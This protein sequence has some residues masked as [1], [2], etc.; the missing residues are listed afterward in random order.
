MT[1]FVGTE[2]D[3]DNIS[4]NCESFTSLDTSTG[5]NIKVGQTVARFYVGYK[6]FEPDGDNFSKY[7]QTK[8]NATGESPMMIVPISD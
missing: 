3:S 8:A 2:N 1:D 7:G 4:M 6:I 5:F